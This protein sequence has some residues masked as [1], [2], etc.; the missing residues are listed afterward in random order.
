MPTP[1]HMAISELCQ[2]D[3]CKYVIS[4]NIDGLHLKSGVPES[5]ISEL[6]GNTNLEICDSCGEKQLRDYRVR[7]ATNVK[8]HKTGRKCAE[9][10]GN[11]CD[12][13]L[14]FGEYYDEDLLDLADQTGQNADVMLCLGSSMRVGIP[15]G[16]VSD[17]SKRKGKVI[18]V[19]LQK[20]PLDKEAHMVIHCRIQTVM[21]KVM[22]KLG[23][24]IPQFTFDRGIDIWVDK[25]KT[26][27]ALG[28]TRESTRY[29][30]FKKMNVN[31]NSKPH[32]HQ[33]KFQFFSHYRENNLTVKIPTKYVEGGKKLKLVMVCDPLK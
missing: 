26:L 4:Q 21:K 33:I 3:I 14:N 15:A 11:L 6:H 17:C 16:I 2:R 31:Y 24:P 28:M 7:T 1:G 23:I 18:I 20:T 8:S 13:I 12:S 5:K 9:C 25:K 30:N 22:Q 29:E 19:N 32:E 10:S 27:Q